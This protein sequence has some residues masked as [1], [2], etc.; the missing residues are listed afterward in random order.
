MSTVIWCESPAIKQARTPGPHGP[1]FE[2]DLLRDV[3]K[4]R[5]ADVVLERKDVYQF[6]RH[7]WEWRIL[8]D[9]NCVA[10]RLTAP[11]GVAS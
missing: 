5:A 11:I 8:I 9:G 2:L 4:D 3:I 1:G 7:S 10:H 6:G